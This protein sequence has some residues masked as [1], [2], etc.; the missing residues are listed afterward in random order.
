MWLEDGFQNKT[1]TTLYPKISCFIRIVVYEI[2]HGDNKITIEHMQRCIFLQEEITMSN[3][4]R[5]GG[6]K[7]LQIAFLW[8]TENNIHNRRESFKLV[9]LCC[10]FS[11]DFFSRFCSRILTIGSDSSRTVDIRDNAR[12]HN[13]ASDVTLK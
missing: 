11:A 10:L 12:Q 6:A 8:T 2:Q 9:L 3:E 4:R 13:V 5:G 1:G 7:L